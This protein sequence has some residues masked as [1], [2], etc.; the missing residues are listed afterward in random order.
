MV[1]LTASLIP[2]EFPVW[3]WKSRDFRKG[4]K[5]S[6]E[7][8][9][10]ISTVEL[11]N[12]TYIMWSAP[13]PDDDSLPEYVKPLFASPSMEMAQSYLHNVQSAYNAGKLARLARALTYAD[14]PQFDL[15][16]ADVPFGTTEQ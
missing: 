4:N 3:V 1:F 15:D 2:E 12:K 14:E 11:S 7:L 13:A 16:L 9:F 5:M 10:G 6:V 8:V